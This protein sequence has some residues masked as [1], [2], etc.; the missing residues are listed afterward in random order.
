[1]SPKRKR[2]SLKIKIGR[3]IAFISDLH[4]G[5][6][7]AVCPDKVKTAEGL[8]LIPSHGQVSLNDSF[9]K[10]IDTCNN[11]AVDTVVVLGDLLEGQN[12]AENG[13][14]LST[15]NLD[16]QI[17]MGVEVL[18]PLVAGRKL[19]VLSG[20]GYHRSVRGLN[21]EK[22]VCDSLGGTWLG[23]L[24]NLKFKPSKR[25]WNLH[26]GYSGS[27]IYREMVLAREGLFSKWAE[28]VGKLPHFDVLVRGHL[29]SFIHIH[30]HDTHLLQLPCWKAFDPNKITL[31]LYAKTQPDIGGCVALI[32]TDD[33]I[34]IHHYLYEAPMISGEVGEV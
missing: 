11:L 32:D 22:Q 1:M 8:W 30:E 28:G 34:V 33:R 26:H 2:S 3:S 9:R 14:G 13:M 7:F 5:S 29:H 23:A 25:V 6:R 31:K 16:E 18:R 4:C 12:V 20:S 21:P 19:L 17:E 15:T 24:A 27:V 10:F